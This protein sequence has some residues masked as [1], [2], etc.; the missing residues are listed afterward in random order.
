MGNATDRVYIANMCGGLLTC[1]S[2]QTHTTDGRSQLSTLGMSKERRF[3]CY[4]NGTYLSLGTP[5]PM[6]I[7]RSY[8]E[9]VAHSL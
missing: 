4:K 6:Q 8:S 9:C 1:T 3:I 2:T 7:M 5:T